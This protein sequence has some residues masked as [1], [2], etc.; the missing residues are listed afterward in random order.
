MDVNKPFELSQLKEG[1]VRVSVRVRVR[2]RVWVRVRVRVKI[3]VP[4]FKLAS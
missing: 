3:I 2:V 4:G 1:C